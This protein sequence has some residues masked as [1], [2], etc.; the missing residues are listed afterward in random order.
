MIMANSD[1]FSV[2]N[3]PRRLVPYNKCLSYNG[4]HNGLRIFDIF[5]IFATNETER[6]Y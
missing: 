6:D 3:T 4:D 1:H 5:P 2:T